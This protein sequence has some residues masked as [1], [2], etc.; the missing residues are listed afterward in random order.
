MW[1]LCNQ[2][3]YGRKILFSSHYPKFQKFLI[4]FNFLIFN[5][6]KKGLLFIVSIF[7]SGIGFSQNCS[8]LFISEY[9]EGRFNNKAIEIY[10]PT[11][12][13]INLS[14]Y[15]VSRYS[16]GSTSATVQ[17]S[18]QLTG[19]IP[20]YGTYVAVLDKR[21]ATGTGNE[22]PIW[23]A[24][25]AKADGFYCPVYTSSDAFY[26]NGNDA[27]LLAKGTLPSTPTTVINATNIPGFVLKDIFGKIG[28]NPGSG[29][30]PLFGWTVNPPYVQSG[31]GVTVD[32]SLIRKL[33]IQK[34]VIANP[35]LFNPLA[36]WDSIPAE[37]VLLDQF[38]DT[39][40][41]SGGADSIVG[42]WN[43]LGIH[44]CSCDPSAAIIS[45]VSEIELSIYP[46][47]TNGIVYIK[48]ASTIVKIQVMNSLGQ[49]VASVDNNSKSVLS[50]DLGSY[51]G[52]YLMKLT[53][54]SGNQITK[55]VIV[56]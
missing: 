36:E 48:G 55:R 17:N 15:F 18:I 27:I 19:T 24:L 53:D 35:A 2:S 46:N 13:A 5:R 23:D 54:V 31:Y 12:N 10:N 56:K 51:R 14:G 16:N 4:N 1:S 39:V 25:Q 28:E 40:L 8:D 26:W 43:S 30:D 52:L 29:S 32:H 3:N 22:A 44:S 11:A 49:L 6:M 37:V 20:A 41:T 47:P 7:T 34:G 9:V 38:G 42:N 33:S 50:M 45:P 21:V